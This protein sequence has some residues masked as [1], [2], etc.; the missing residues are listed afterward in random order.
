MVRAYPA[1][2]ATAPAFRE[3]PTRLL[4]VPRDPGVA[5]KWEIGGLIGLILAYLAA[6]ELAGE[7]LVSLLNAAGPLWLMGVLIFGAVRMARPNPDNV[8]SSLFWFRIATAIYFG[9]GN[10]VPNI[11]N[12]ATKL[13]MEAFFLFDDQHLL[14][15][16]MIVAVSTLTTLFA[17]SL[18][19]RLGSRHLRPVS[20]QGNDRQLLLVGSAFALVGFVVKFGFLLPYTLGTTGDEVVTGTFATVGLLAPVSIYLLARYVLDHRPAL[21]PFIIVALLLDMGVGVLTFN[22]SEVLVSLIMFLMAYLGRGLTVWRLT[23]AAAAMLM[24]FVQIVPIADYGRAQMFG[25]YRSIG[26][27]GLAERFQI[28]E[29]Y[30]NEP[31][32]VGVEEG[33][34]GALS[35]LSYANAGSFAIDQFD[36]GFP[37]RTLESALAV[38]VPRVLWPDKPIISDLGREFNLLAT[39]NP[40]SFSSP[41]IFAEAYWNSGWWGVIL[42]MAAVGVLLGGI[43][44]FAL[45]WMTQRRWLLFP[46][47]ILGMRMGFRVDGMLVVDYIGAAGL[48]AVA[49]VSIALVERFVMAQAGRPPPRAV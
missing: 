6:G 34:Q 25:R 31:A 45:R 39:N 4:G 15:L 22:K 30:L 1:R 17:A 47:V 12:T 13:Y 16:N 5:A 3:L 20:L 38:L 28:V 23:V 10:F 11:V 32:A 21:L 46:V 36:R 42:L 35:R 37:G 48:A 7:G 8:W 27:G 33:V 18:I 29:G 19:G 9:F 14:K 44:R 40:N 41:G 26:V 2:R 49:Y 43:S 24:T